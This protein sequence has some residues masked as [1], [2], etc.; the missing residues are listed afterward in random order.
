MKSDG[1]KDVFKWIEQKCKEQKKIVDTAEEERRANIGWRLF[2]DTQC[3]YDD[4]DLELKLAN[5][6]LKTLV[7]VKIGVEKY[8]KKLKHN[9][10]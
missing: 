10:E 4:A 8:M 9:G 1:V 5:E 7:E 6:R 3:L 2:E